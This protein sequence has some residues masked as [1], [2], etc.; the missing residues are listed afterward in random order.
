MREGG[1]GR[2]L[3]SFSRCI[4]STDLTGSGLIS[5]HSVIAREHSM[6]G[7]AEDY[8]QAIGFHNL[9]WPDATVI[10]NSHE[11]EILINI[12]IRNILG[13]QDSFSSKGYFI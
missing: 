12:T 8:C 5:P 7:I 9:V 11:R 3:K 13:Y 4:Y 2:G 10:E 6:H 1:G